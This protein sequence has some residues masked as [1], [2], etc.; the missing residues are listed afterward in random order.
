MISDTSITLLSVTF[1]AAFLHLL[2]EYLAFQ[3]DISFWKNN[4]S[5]IGLSIR[6]LF[7]DFLSQIIIFLFL[8]DNQT[9]MLIIVPS[10]I[11][12]LIQI[13]KIHRATGIRLS[14]K[15]ENKFFVKIELARVTEERN[16]GLLEQQQQQQLLEK[17]QEQEQEKKD[18]ADH[19]D[20]GENNQEK[21]QEEPATKEALEKLMVDVSLEADAFATK[22]L[23]WSLF[24]MILCFVLYSLVFSKYRSW[25]SWLISSL[26]SCVYAFG[27]I[28]MCPQ[29]YINH[30]LKSVSYLPWQVSRHLTLLSFHFI[31]F[32][33]VST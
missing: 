19:Q 7:T 29:L 3:S 31:S 33:V 25:Y 10:F 9:S 14:F 2:F 21:S 30:K 18:D 32:L 20:E 16:E 12:I 6:T 13:W 27:F 15:K 17:E 26:T 22:Y 11:A 24:P 4:K 8:L 5:L 23:S 28:L 1:L